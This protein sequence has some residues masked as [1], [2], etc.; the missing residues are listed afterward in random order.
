[1]YIQKIHPHQSTGWSTQTVN[2]K[3]P[4]KSRVH[5]CCWHN[6]H[7]CMQYTIFTVVCLD[8][9]LLNES[10]VG[11]SGLDI[12]A[13]PLAQASVKSVGRVQITD[14]SPVWRVRF[15]IAKKLIK[16]H[17]KRCFLYSVLPTNL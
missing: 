8:A 4:Q 12:S 13:R 14:H 11:V 10:E 15:F 16:L 3:R 9:W 2:T 1:M 5:D 7:H 6:F 17:N